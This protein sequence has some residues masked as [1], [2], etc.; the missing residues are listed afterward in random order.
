MKARKVTMPSKTAQHS[1]SLPQVI[2]R[3]AAMPNGRAL[4]EVLKLVQK[5]T[6]SAK[7]RVSTDLHRATLETSEGGLIAVRVTTARQ[8]Y[9]HGACR[10]RFKSP[11]NAK[12]FRVL[13]FGGLNERGA[14]IVNKLTAAE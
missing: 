4:A 3:V 7:V 1:G 10:F 14:A 12:Q 8:P 6:D 13:Y 11:S 5:D 9:V 2:E